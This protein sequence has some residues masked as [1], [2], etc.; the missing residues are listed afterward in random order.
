V[1]LCDLVIVNNFFAH[2]ADGPAHHRQVWAAAHPRR[3][4]H[5]TVQSIA[6][7]MLEEVRSPTTACQRLGKPGNVRCNVQRMVTDF[8][9][10]RRSIVGHT[11]PLTEAITQHALRST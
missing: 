10:N 3:T 9:N 2:L 5:R 8:I 7:N 1:G 6:W 11:Q 4:G